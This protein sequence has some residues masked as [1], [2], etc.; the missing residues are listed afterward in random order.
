MA[1]ETLHLKILEDNRDTIVQSNR[2]YGGE[3]EIIEYL[4]GTKLMLTV[5]PIGD[6]AGILIEDPTLVDVQV[7][8]SVYDNL[9]V[10]RTDEKLIHL[11]RG[12][13][14]QIWSRIADKEVWLINDYSEESED[15]N[16]PPISLNA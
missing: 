7:Y 15:S 9:G 1:I 4:P 10:E 5:S 6:N 2:Y 12:Y 3:Q 13:E 11:K 14:I 8:E 16:F